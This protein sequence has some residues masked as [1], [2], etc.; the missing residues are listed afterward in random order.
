MKTSNSKMASSVTKSSNVAAI[1]TP[2]IFSAMKM[3]YAPKA[4][5]FGASDGNCTLRYAPMAS[6][7]AGGAK[8]NSTNVAAPAK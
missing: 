4:A 7:M 3:R 5:C 8:T 2:I 1:C 6:A